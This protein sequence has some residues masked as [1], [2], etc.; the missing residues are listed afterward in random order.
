[1]TPDQ[2]Q[3]LQTILIGL[4][5]LFY[6][7]LWLDARQARTA[8]TLTA[9][10]MVY[11]SFAW[12][13]IT[14]DVLLT[15]V[16]VNTGPVAAR[17]VK[18]RVWLTKDPS[19]KARPSNVI[20]DVLVPPCT[21]IM[22]LNAG[23]DETAKGQRI[24]RKMVDDGLFFAAKW[25]WTDGRGWPLFPFVHRRHRGEIKAVPLSNIY[26]GWLGSNFLIDQPHSV[27]SV[28]H[29][30]EQRD[31]RDKDQTQALKEIASSLQDLVARSAR[32]SQSPS[33]RA[34]VVGLL[35]RVRSKIGSR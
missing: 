10:V 1:M 21:R 6:A 19:L 18:A 12:G 5:V 35:E 23:P 2:V 7:L 28:A 27:E 25:E 16:M 9:E 17:N 33:H 24:T 32:D 31:N 13:A 26:T 15:A 3:N 4:T 8:A 29:R 11:P 22:V 14:I 20:W 30:E 34:R